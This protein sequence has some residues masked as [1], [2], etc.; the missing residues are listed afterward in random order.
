MHT[1]TVHCAFKSYVVL[2]AYTSCVYY[3]II[4]T[5]ISIIIIICRKPRVARVTVSKPIRAVEKKMKKKAT[6][7]LRSRIRLTRALII[8][9]AMFLMIR[10]CLCVWCRSREFSVDRFWDLRK[11]IQGTC[12][13]MLS[14]KTVSDK[15]L[16]VKITEI[17]IVLSVLPTIRHFGTFR[18]G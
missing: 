5:I 18:R 8:R 2:Y 17:R 4:R 9:T 16:R 13:K 10:V 12:Y 7:W 15:V 11:N 1:Y 14:E 6:L 3:I